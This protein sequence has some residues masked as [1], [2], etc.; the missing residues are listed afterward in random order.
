MLFASPNKLHPLDVLITI[1]PKQKSSHPKHELAG[2]HMNDHDENHAVWMYLFL[3]K[4]YKRW[5]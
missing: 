4:Y 1:I 2:F 5:F 3:M